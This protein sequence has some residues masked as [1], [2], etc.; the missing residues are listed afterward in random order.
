MQAIILKHNRALNCDFREK[1]TKSPTYAAN[2]TSNKAVARITY[3]G[4]Y[5]E[6]HHTRSV[7]KVVGLSQLQNS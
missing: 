7:L 5:G 2:K 1:Y 4:E 3:V 6:V